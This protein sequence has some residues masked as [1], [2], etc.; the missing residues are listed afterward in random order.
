MACLCRQ[1]GEPY[2]GTTQSVCPCDVT[3]RL[4]VDVR[5]GEIE[6][7]L[8]SAVGAAVHFQGNGRLHRQALLAEIENHAAGDAIETGKDWAIHLMAETTSSVCE[9]H[10]LPAPCLAYECVCW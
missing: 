1:I 4:E 7:E 6:A 9:H 5:I 3:G 8:H 10:E 2:S